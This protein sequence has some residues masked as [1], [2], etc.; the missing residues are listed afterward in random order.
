MPQRRVPVATGMLAFHF[1]LFMGGRVKKEELTIFSRCELLDDIRRSISN[2]GGPLI[3]TCDLL[4]R[5]E[6]LEQMLGKDDQI[7]DIDDSVT[8]RHWADVT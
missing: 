4:S 6:F 1:E 5:R 7:L 3:P 2:E 8:P